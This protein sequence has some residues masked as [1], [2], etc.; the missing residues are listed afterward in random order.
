[1]ICEHNEK[2]A[3]HDQKNIFNFVT[4]IFFNFWRGLIRPIFLFPYNKREWK[5][6]KYKKSP[7]NIVAI[8]VTI[9]AVNI[10]TTSNTT[11]HVSIKWRQWKY[12]KYI[13]NPHSIYALRVTKILKLI[14]DYGNIRT[15][16]YPRPL[17]HKYQV[18]P[19]NNSRHRQRI[20]K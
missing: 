2:L 13:N 19:T 10:V 12:W 8:R 6:W 7:I 18:T 11:A 14:Q 5:Y 16:A 17:P 20:C 1:M 15:N 9:N 4:I 3:S